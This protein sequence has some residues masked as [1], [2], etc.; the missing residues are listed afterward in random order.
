MVRNP[1]TFEVRS[2]CSRHVPYVVTKL[3]MLPFEKMKETVVV[4][5]NSERVEQ[6]L[7]SMAIIGIYRHTEL[8]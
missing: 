5:V 3:E 8:F 1:K 6:I 7:P 4:R 2:A